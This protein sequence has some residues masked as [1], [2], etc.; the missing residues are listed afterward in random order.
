MITILISPNNDT[1]LTIYFYLK[2]YQFHQPMNSFK[3]PFTIRRCNK[4]ILDGSLVL[5]WSM[6]LISLVTK[7]QY[8]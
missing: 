3:T 5:Y 4:K 7:F 1:P 8:T 6:K 2:T